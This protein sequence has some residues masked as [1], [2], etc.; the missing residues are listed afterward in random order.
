MQYSHLP[1]LIRVLAAS[2]ILACAPAAAEEDISQLKQQIEELERKVRLLQDRQATDA[3]AAAR[4]KEPAFVT[5][6][7][8]GFGIMSG[9][10]AFRLNLH[11]D[12][13]VD[14]RLSQGTGSSGT[15][16]TQAPDTLLV[17]RARPIIEATLY[18]TYDFRLMP[19]F[20]GSQTV[21]FDAYG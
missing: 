14:S 21:L 2:I 17:R 6:G 7:S 16:G 5:A 13:Q 1:A 8:E 3:E 11:G 9:D 4:V 15:S 12:L 20:A 18:D 19:D 10:N